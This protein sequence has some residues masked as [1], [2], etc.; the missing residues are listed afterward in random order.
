MDESSL[1]PALL[2]CVCATH[3]ALWGNQADT[4][5]PDEVIRVRF[6]SSVQRLMNENYLVLVIATHLLSP[7][8]KAVCS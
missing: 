1:H 8:C 2:T 5:W 4:S 6:L 7:L 3:S